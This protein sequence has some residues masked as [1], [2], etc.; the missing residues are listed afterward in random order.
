MISFQNILE[1]C[2]NPHKRGKKGNEGSCE[3]LLVYEGDV[4]SSGEIRNRA[5]C[6]GITNGKQHKGGSYNKDQKTVEDDLKYHNY[7]K[8]IM[9]QPVV[10]PCNHGYCQECITNHMTDMVSSF[11]KFTHNLQYFYIKKL[12]LS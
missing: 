2:N 9:M 8:R 4:N 1:A 3:D 11:N 7:N 12:H 5:S 10:L 6:C